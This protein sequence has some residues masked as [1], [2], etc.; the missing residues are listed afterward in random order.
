MYPSA[1]LFL[2][3]TEHDR[4]GKSKLLYELFVLGNWGG[5]GE[6]RVCLR[7]QERTC[8]TTMFWLWLSTSTPFSIIV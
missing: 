2:K 7:V 1:E 6:H 4:T 5:L 3:E 8:H